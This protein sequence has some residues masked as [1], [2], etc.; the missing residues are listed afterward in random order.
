MKLIKLTCNNCNAPLEVDID[1]L[2]AY[3]PYCGQKLLFDLEQME[4]VLAEKEQTKRAK[5]R[6]KRAQE[7][8]KR[9]Q[10]EYEY[11][12]KKHRR[13]KAADRNF[14]IGLALFWCLLMGFL[15]FM[16]Y[17]EKQEHQNN[18]EVQ[19]SVSSKD[20]KEE[21]VENAKEILKNCGFQYVNT[22]NKGD[23]VFGFFSKE[24]EIDSIS[25]NGNKK[26]SKGD[27]FPSDSVVVITYHGF[28]KD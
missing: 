7:A 11:E 9:V 24:G 20:L 27:W 22:T 26:F 3:C 12:D 25:I 4:R 17:N 15:F 23:L 2:Q 14:G 1:N 18:N 8:T 16:D 6:T 28:S 5:E 10:I 21:T 19:V 13:E